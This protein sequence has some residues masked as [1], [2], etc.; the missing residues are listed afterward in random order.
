MG[1][2]FITYA[3]LIEI[4]NDLIDGL[5]NGDI[6]FLNRNVFDSIIKGNNFNR[7]IFYKLQQYKCIENNNA[8]LRLL[9]DPDLSSHSCIYEIMNFINEIGQE[10]EL[11][12]EQKNKLER[13]IKENNNLGNSYKKIEELKSFI[14]NYLF[15]EIKHDIDLNNYSGIINLYKLMVDR[16]GFL[17][18][19]EVFKKIVSLKGDYFKLCYNM[20]YLARFVIG[21]EGKK[22]II[23]KQILDEQYE[24]LSIFYELCLE[25]NP[26]LSKVNNLL[27]AYES[28]E[29][30]YDYDLLSSLVLISTEDS[31]EIDYYS[32]EYNSS[33]NQKF[34]LFLISKKVEFKNKFNIINY[35]EIRYKELPNY[36]SMPTR[37]HEEDAGADV[38]AT[39]DIVLNPGDRYKMPL[40][41]A[42][43]IPVGSM[44][45]IYTKSGTFI[46]G[47]ISYEPP[48][49][50][51]YT[52]EIHALLH[53]I[54]NE[55]IIIKK[56]D[57]VGQLI[58]LPIYLPK[59]KKTEEELISGERGT[60]GFGST[61]ASLI[62]K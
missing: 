28:G 57:K 19:K 29:L 2:K 41:I 51:G 16:N 4:L 8:V 10:T 24:T 40:G 30:E 54:N 60:G 13:L 52:G 32:Y 1:N 43:E 6:K 26:F 5:N 14:G 62:K 33:Y 48:I 36:V 61:G 56:G 22:N 50:A 31:E 15:E 53:N 47:L 20:V 23:Y 35:G 34:N 59:F 12:L 17:D 38:Y 11:T 9:N 18:N 37:S 58:L 42:I 25:N 3:D 7:F 45:V 46:K 44:A 27:K 49:D 39:K 21:E 55:P